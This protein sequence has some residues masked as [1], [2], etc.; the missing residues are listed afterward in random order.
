MALDSAPFLKLQKAH[1]RHFDFHVFQ[2]EKNLIPVWVNIQ[3][4]NTF[5][6]ISSFWV[7][8]PFKRVLFCLAVVK[9]RELFPKELYFDNLWPTAVSFCFVRPVKHNH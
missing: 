2:K 4:S 1:I 3:V 5:L 6:R 7:D 9:H 8:F